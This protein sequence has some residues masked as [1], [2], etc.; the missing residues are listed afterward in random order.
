[1]AMVTSPPEQC[2]TLSD[3]SWETYE[4]L[5]GDHV[6]C[7]A[8][9][10]TYDRGALEIV[11]TLSQLREE[12]NAI[13]WSFVEHIAMEWSV[14]TY[15][16]GSMTFVHKGIQQG[17]SPDTVFYIQH[18]PHVRRIGQIYPTIHPPPD[19]V[20]EIDVSRDSLDKL[21]VYAGFGV[22]EVWRVRD[23]AVIVYSLRP[24]G[25]GNYDEGSP[26]RVLPPLDGETL[27]RFLADGLTLGRA[28]WVRSIRA[29]AQ[30]VSG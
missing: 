14:D 8:P 27:T 19:L 25:S 13:V 3:V 9:R 18:A 30:G 15:C 11:G 7:Q 21:P 4:R 1:M 17:F 6:D 23:G 22:P 26:S 2:V 29:W 20:I 12:P 28:E 24:D 16:V 5:L 10:L